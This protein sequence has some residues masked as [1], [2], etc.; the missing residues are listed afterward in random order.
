MYRNS[1]PANQG[2]N[3]LLAIALLQTPDFLKITELL[4][5][6]GVIL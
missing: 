6:F 3:I 5:E 2:I 1:S 4:I